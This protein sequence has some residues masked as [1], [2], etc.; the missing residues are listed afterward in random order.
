M[1]TFPSG[2]KMRGILLASTIVL[3]PLLHSPAATA[4]FAGD[5]ARDHFRDTSILRPPMGSK[6]ALIVFED[7]GCPS[8]AT[9][10]PFE[11]E[12]VKQT[13][14]TLLRYDFPIEAHVWTFE[15]AVCA[16]YV[17]ETYGAQ[18]AEDFRS[19][20]FRA[21]REIYTNEDIRDFL[22]HWLEKRGKKMPAALDPTGKLAKEVTADRNLGLRLNVE[23]TPT[24]VVVTRN[25]YQVVC[26]TKDGANDPAQ[27]LAVVKGAMAQAR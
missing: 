1:L 5:G 3:A 21:Q 23:W 12:A 16:R 11:V 10:H 26:G 27:I 6:V 13:H 2:A 17:E 18:V 14:V 15:G 4:Q 8:C 25:N 22:T 20:V 7:L 9:A 19:A 24:V